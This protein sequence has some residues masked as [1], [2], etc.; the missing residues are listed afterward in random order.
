MASRIVRE[1][2][3]FSFLNIVWVVALLMRHNSPRLVSTR[4]ILTLWEHFNSKENN[5]F[6]NSLIRRT[7]FQTI[8]SDVFVYTTM[9]RDDLINHAKQYIHK[10]QVYYN[11]NSSSITFGYCVKLL[12]RPSYGDYTRFK[13]IIGVK[14]H[15]IWLIYVFQ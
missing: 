9:I 11:I 12:I 7:I 5:L 4:A 6:F 14:L 10:I 15:P 13:E 3:Y 1:E 2:K 8:S